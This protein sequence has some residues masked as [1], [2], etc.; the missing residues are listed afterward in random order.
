MGD[1]K[2]PL[3]MYVTSSGHCKTRKGKLDVETLLLI[4]RNK[5]QHTES[6]KL[7]IQWQ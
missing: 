1:K 7:K 4:V 2:S 5:A 3:K 6:S